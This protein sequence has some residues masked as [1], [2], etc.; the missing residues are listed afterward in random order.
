MT[1][2]KE[3]FAEEFKKLYG[4][5]EVELPSHIL[6]INDNYA[7]PFSSGSNGYL[8]KV[9]LNKDDKFEFYHDWWAYRWIS[10]NEVKEKYP[11]TVSEIESLIESLVESLVKSKSKSYVKSCTDLGQSKRLIEIL[12]IESA[13]M[14]IG[15]YVGKS[16]EV[17]GTNIHYYFKGE[18]FGAP[19]IIEAWSLAALL[20]IIPGGQ[21][22][23]M[24]NSDKWEASSWNDSDFEPICE[25]EGYDNAIDACYELILKLH[26]ENLV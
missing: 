16:G 19:Q 7:S 8:T 4:N 26:E 10:F 17:D 1:T 14:R 21:V 3:K 6:T 22:N 2:I 11:H 5:K 18:S 20:N 9:R 24:T 12:P 15:N 25:V 23:R 13:D